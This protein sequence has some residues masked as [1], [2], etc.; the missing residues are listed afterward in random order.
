MLSHSPAI[1]FFAPIVVGADGC[2]LV[3]ICSTGRGSCRPTNGIPRPGMVDVGCACCSVATRG[4]ARVVERQHGV[5]QP[6]WGN[7]C[8]APNPNDP[9][10]VDDD[11][12]QVSAA[13]V[14][15]SACGGGIGPDLAA[16]QA[17]QQGA[18]RLCPRQECGELGTN[19]QLWA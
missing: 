16:K 5:L 2:K 18:R 11:C 17:S 7:A 6:S 14:D 15:Q 12:S 10:T 19:K 3:D 4:G 13:F 8:A 1:A 9:S